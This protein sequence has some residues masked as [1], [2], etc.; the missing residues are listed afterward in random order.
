MHS[1]HSQEILF[2]RLGKQVKIIAVASGKG[3]VGKST[4]A[5]NLA[6]SLMSGKK[7]VGL[8][9]GDI[10]GPSIPHLFRMKTA[11]KITKDGALK[12]LQ[13]QG[14][15]F[16]SMGNLLPPQV[17]T[18]WR[19]PMVVKALKQF[20][21]QVDWPPLD[22]LIVDMP[23]GTGDVQLTLAQ[24]VP[25]AGAVIVLMP[26]ALSQFDA[27]KAI[28]MFIQV[29]TNILGAIENMISYVCPHCQTESFPFQE[30]VKPLDIDILGRI[31]LL[32]QV[33]QTAQLPFKERQIS[34]YFEC[35][36]DKILKKLE[37][38]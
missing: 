35:I 20:L 3:G 32:S 14:I 6:S 22:Y 27:Q 10:Y 23:P 8:L 30:S 33:T 5:F 31:P 18:V 36:T 11:P 1:A 24:S 12:P 29:G 21:F 25:L 7:R 26:D 2:Q 4:V 34:Q 13:S 16:I 37:K 38:K 9:D 28:D 19:G 15:S 17:A